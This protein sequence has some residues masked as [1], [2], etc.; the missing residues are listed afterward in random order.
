MINDYQWLPTVTNDYSYLTIKD[1][2]RLSKT[3]KDY[4]KDFQKYYQKYWWYVDDCMVNAPLVT[5]QD[6]FI[7]I[8]FRLYIMYRWL[9]GKWWSSDASLITRSV[10]Q[11]ILTGATPIQSLDED[12][13]EDNLGNNNSNMKNEHQGG[14]WKLLVLSWNI[15]KNIGIELVN[16]CPMIANCWS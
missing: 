8:I 7:D 1:Y 12:V 3:I 14:F 11:W 16:N 4:Q 5:A 10:A 9:H 2:Q 6:D 15:S 13:E